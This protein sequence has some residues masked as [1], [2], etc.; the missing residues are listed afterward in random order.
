MD[1]QEYSWKKQDYEKHPGECDRGKTLSHL[2]NIFL[3]TGID[4]NI[5]VFQHA[6]VAKHIQAKQ[7]ITESWG[8]VFWFFLLINDLW[9]FGTTS[10]SQLS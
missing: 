9:Y 10:C 4:S 8:V 6:F 5:S 2:Q 7:G 3:G 1:F